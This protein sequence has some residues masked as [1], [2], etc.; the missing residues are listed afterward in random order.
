MEEK[1]KF[2]YEIEAFVEAFQDKKDKRIA[3]YG[4][5]RMTATLL[6][7]LT[8][9]QIVGLLDR[10][11]ELI[12]KELY[13]KE[14]ISKERAEDIADIIV[15]NTAETYWNTIYSRIRT[16]KLP[17]YFRNGRLAVQEENENMEDDPYWNKSYEELRRVITEYEVISFDIFDTLIMRKFFLPVDIFRLIEKKVQNCY[18][19]QY[20]FVEL[21]KRASGMLDNPTL[22]EIYS[23]MKEL[24]GWDEQIINDIKQCEWE[25][26]VQLIVARKDMLELCKEIIK[27][28]EIYFV[29][30]MYY[31]AEQ[32]C[33]ILARIG[34]KIDEKR[35]LVSCEYKKSKEEGTLWQY[36][37]EK[38]VLSRKVLHIGD[39]EKADYIIPQSYGINTYFVRNANEI[40]KHSSLKEVIPEVNSLYSSLILGLI[41]V[42]LCNSPFSLNETKG[43]ICFETEEDTGYCLLGGLCYSFL[44][45]LMKNARKD[46]VEKIAFFAREGYLLIEQYH[47]MKSL[48]KTINL[49]DAVYLEISR[50]AIINA[51]VEKKQDVYEVATFPYT[52]S[53]KEFLHDRFRVDTEDVKVEKVSAMELQRDKETLE[54]MLSKY[55]DTIF[56]KTQEERGNYLKY[57]SEIGLEKNIGIVDSLLYGNTQYYLGKLLKEKLQG[58]Y[59]CACL[60]EN[61]KC[62]Q[63]QHMKGCFQKKEDITGKDTKVWKNSNFIEAFFT[64]PKG[65]LVYMDSDGK[66]HYAELMSNQRNFEVRLQMEKGILAFIKDVIDIQE[67]INFE[68]MCQDTSFAD[69]LFG[70]FMECGFE[71]SG[72][73]KKSFF[74]DNGILNHKEAPIWE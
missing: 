51:S 1:S 21:R 10:D 46:G 43:K 64:S 7:K 28:K 47:Y 35:I 67:G 61:N 5:G 20:K 19:E 60:D 62:F 3:I 68:E 69:Y 36:Y 15:I 24:S 25:T 56:E 11:E 44:F 48:L 27:E 58:Y 41:Q 40:M 32:L 26:D 23:K 2:D 53:F 8:E 73:M 34:L 71:P 45:W 18:G 50:R 17:I 54:R 33:Q 70:S 52:G 13:G 6:S 55:S 22:D 39:N 31:S 4:T 59:F 12:G 57:L 49:P 72:K 16:W 74:Y 66:G 30:D 42:R 65:M 14:I 38:I 29:S 37:Q 63:H 9:F